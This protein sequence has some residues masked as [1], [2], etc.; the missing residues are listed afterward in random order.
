MSPAIRKESRKKKYVWA[1]FGSHKNLE[2]CS[3]KSKI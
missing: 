2:K 1:H 3:G